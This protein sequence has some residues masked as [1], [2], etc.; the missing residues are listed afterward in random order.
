MALPPDE[1]AELRLAAI[2][3][4]SDDAIIGKDL[5][6]TITSWNRAAER[7]FGYSEAEAV[8]Q[9]ILLIVPPDLHADEAEVLRRIRG[10]E[11][12]EHYETDRVRKSGERIRVSLTVSPIRTKSGEVIGT[13]TIVRDI[14]ERVQLE[15]DARW[16][17]AIINSSDDVIVSKDLNGI[18]AVVEPGRRAA[19][20]LHR[21]GDGRP[22]D[23]R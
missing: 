1:L 21:R 5:S 13:S 12:V 6:G 20:R 17:T 19:V 22:L 2:V 14:H 10:G 11:S 8:G 4:S 3:S 18:V 16:L 9:S 15:R 23:S 7:I